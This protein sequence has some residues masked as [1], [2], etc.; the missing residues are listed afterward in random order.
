MFLTFLQGRG[1]SNARSAGESGPAGSQPRPADEERGTHAG[2]EGSGGH[3]SQDDQLPG[4]HSM[5]QSWLPALGC[6]VIRIHSTKATEAAHHLAGARP[7]SCNHKKEHT[8]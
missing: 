4:G 7:T 6:K 1:G 2:G 8:E 5:L 3:L